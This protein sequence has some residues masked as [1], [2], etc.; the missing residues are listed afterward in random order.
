MNVFVIGGGAA[1]MF[2]SI[3]A[4]RQGA[5]VTVI[6]KNEKLGKKLYITGKGRCN[7]TNYTSF[8]QYLENIVSNPKFLYGAIKSFDC[9]NLMA[10]F[11]NIGV[12][13]KVERG[14]RVF[15]Q[16]DKSSDI[17]KALVKEMES[18]NVH[19]HLNEKVIDLVQK[20]GIIE[21][22]VTNVATYYPDK[23]ILATGGA[24]YTATGSTG[25]GYNF[26]KKLGHTIV[27]LRPALVPINLKSVQRADKSNVNL[28]T[29]PK[30]QGLSLKNIN[31]SACQ[32][33]ETVVSEFGELLFTANGISGPTALSLSSKINRRNLN[34]LTIKIDLKP[35]LSIEE[36]DAR[37][38]RDFSNQINKAY[39]NS[40]N[41]LL[42]SSLIPFFIKI[43][44][45]DEFKK[46]NLITKEERT[47]LVYL[48]KNLTF[49]ILDLEKIES[50]IVTAGGVSTKEISPSTMQSKLISNL[51]FAGEIIDADALTGGF[52]LQIAFSTAYLAANKLQA[53]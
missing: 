53:R 39:K 21:K 26:A 40:L 6:E 50:G 15:P 36:L 42:P 22:I 33:E 8:E 2:A 52:N 29:L 28:A 35:A 48:L 18:S 34:T 43:S 12:S 17:I 38:L 47:K 32:G 25:D 49:S 16:S 51:Y 27:P 10:F 31:L 14:N 44:Q 5:K 13:L 7:L 3:F 19:V 23:V 41:M 24:S 9:D 1:G 30:L 45:I 37:V 11:E 20:E 46:V 4:A